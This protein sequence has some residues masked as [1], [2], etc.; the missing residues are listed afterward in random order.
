[1]GSTNKTP[2]SD[3]TDLNMK[4][5]GLVLGFLAIGLR[6]AEAKPKKDRAPSSI[7]NCECQCTNLIYKDENGKV[8][9]NCRSSDDTGAQ[10]CYVEAGSTCQDIQTTTTVQDEPWS[11]EACATPVCPP[12]ETANLPGS[13][14][15]TTLFATCDNFM[16][17]YVDGELAHE[18]PDFGTDTYQWKTESEITIPIGTRV[19]GIECQDAGGAYGILASTANGI[20]TD[21]SWTCTS[22]QNIQGWS[23]PEFIDTNSDFS[24]SSPS[25][26]DLQPKNPLEPEKISK[27][28]K[29]IWGPKANGWAFCKLSMPV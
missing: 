28:A 19:L 18:D 22:T 15:E 23:K 11:Y 4:N 1:M 7:I 12:A 26:S 5:I 29:W 6:L 20:L 27:E 14:I 8:H 2:N 3:K 24:A 13:T 16:R 25:Y 10:W 17:V 21:Q 9:G